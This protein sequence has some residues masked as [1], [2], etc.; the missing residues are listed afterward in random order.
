VSTTLIGGPCVPAADQMLQDR[1]RAD[2]ASISREK[3]LIG[4]LQTQTQDAVSAER[5]ISAWLAAVSGALGLLV[6]ALATIWLRNRPRRLAV[7]ASAASPAPEATAAPEATPVP[8]PAAVAA[9]SGA[10][11]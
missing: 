7:P 9:P 5:R 2:E 1:L 6:I 3:D 8:A 11:P 4:R 10:A